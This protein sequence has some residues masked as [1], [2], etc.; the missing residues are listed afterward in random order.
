MT[1]LFTSAPARPVLIPPVPHITINGKYFA[2]DPQ[3]HLDHVP[4]RNA[5]SQ[6]VV[7][8]RYSDFYRHYAVTLNDVGDMPDVIWTDDLNIPIDV[9]DKRIATYLTE[10]QDGALREF[11]NESMFPKQ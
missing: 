9:D 6:Q 8:V 2:A 5:F 3:D 1:T 7:K 11:I 10:K 4:Y